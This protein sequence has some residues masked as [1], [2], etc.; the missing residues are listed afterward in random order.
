MKQSQLVF[1]YYLTNPG[2]SQKKAYMLAYPNSSAKSAEVGASRML[3]N[4][5]FQ[6]HL[7]LVLRKHAIGEQALIDSLRALQNSRDWRAWDKF[8][9]WTSKFLGVY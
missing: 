2:Y 7:S 6:E 5:K 3:R 4:A 8:I 1:A 9:E